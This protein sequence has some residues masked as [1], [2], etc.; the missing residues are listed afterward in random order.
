[1]AGVPSSDFSLTARW[2]I[3]VEGPPLERGTVSIRGDRLAAIEPRGYRTPD[4]DAGE[5]AVLPGF[6]NAHTHLDLSDLR[7]KAPPSADF[8]GWLRAVIRHRRE[9]SNEETIRAIRAGLTEALSFGTTLVGDIAGSGLSWETLS[10]A[11]LRAVVFYELLGLSRSRAKIAWQEA[12]AWLETHAP[13]ATCTP[14]LSPHAP[15]S[16]RK[17][18]FRLAGQSALARRLP[19]AVH[20]AESAEEIELVTAHSGPFVDFLSELG[21]WDLPG[22]VPDLNQVLQIFANNQNV[23]FIHANY[24]RAC[25]TGGPS[26]NPE[27]TATA[28]LDPRR[29]LGAKRYTVPSLLPGLSFPPGATIVYCPRTHAAFGH[30]LHPVEDFLAAGVRVALGTDSLASNPDL[31]L[32]EEARFLHQRHPSIPGPTVVRMATLSGAEALGWA[33]ETGSLT[34]GKSADLVLVPLSGNGDDPHKQVLRSNGSARAVM[35]RGRWVHGDP[36]FQPAT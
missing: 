19:V 22:L 33:H 3:P 15:Y 29:W 31:N 5:V 14:A 35:F 7:A 9:R 11:P 17:S 26:F 10:S 8:T 27:P 32:L 13:T 18:L 12:Y 16:V 30:P 28:N 4:V 2:I 1:M 6:V 21:V 23:L 25:G 20:L 34:P 24:L 36:R